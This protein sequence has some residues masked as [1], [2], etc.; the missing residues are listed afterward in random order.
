MVADI[1]IKG[2]RKEGR[3][4]AL[5]INARLAEVLGKVSKVLIPASAR[6]WVKRRMEL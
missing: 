4:D 3:S 1:R 2:G 5:C 6:V